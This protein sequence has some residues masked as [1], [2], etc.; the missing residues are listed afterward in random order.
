MAEGFVPENPLEEAMVAAAADPARFAAFLD[1]LRESDVFV[2]GRDW[3]EQP[4]PDEPPDSIDLPVVE[5]QGRL[6]VPVFTSVTRLRAVIEERV[7]VMAFNFRDLAAIWRGDI[8]ML[9][10]PGAALGIPLSPSQVRDEPSTTVDIPAGTQ[11]MVGEPAVEPRVLLD[12]VSEVCAGHPEILVAHR[13]E[14]IFEV[15]GEVPHA[16]IGLE[17][18]HRV[19]SPEA[20]CR[21]LV[22]EIRKGGPMPE[23][24]LMVVDPDSPGPIERHMVEKQ[25]PFYRRDGDD[26]AEAAPA[27]DA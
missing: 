1:L 4:V 9:V 3:Q 22:A 11:V 24:D 18:E 16:A 13:A 7:T 20:Y 23:F 12:R 8:W 26:E 6:G 14:V 19:A 15:P 2:P 25:A 10:N 21:A 27:G 17:L 5:W